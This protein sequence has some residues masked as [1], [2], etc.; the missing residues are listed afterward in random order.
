MQTFT[1]IFARICQLGPRNSPFRTA[2]AADQ[3]AALCRELG[4][5]NPAWEQFE[6]YSDAYANLCLGPIDRLVFTAHYDT[7]GPACGACD[8]SSGV[9]VALAAA[10]IAKAAGAE[11]GLLI[12]AC[13]EPPFFAR[14]MG[15]QDWVARHSSE[16][17]N[18]EI[19]VIDSL[20]GMHKPE[21]PS[22]HPSRRTVT[23]REL[24]LLAP[25]PQDGNAWATDVGLE[26]DIPNFVDLTGNSIRNLG[27]TRCMT[28]LKALL[29]LDSHT[30]D[31][32]FHMPQDIPEAVDVAWLERVAN[33]LAAL[34]VARLT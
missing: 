18:A 33:S 21:S 4:L 9:A 7:C 12:N 15:S 22:G 34:A 24:V 8:N 27:D 5:G 30:M 14:K 26:L 29:L 13:E 3:I 25:S 2:V 17:T 11:V 10:A 1:N 16:L 31:V 6:S 32:P 19:I 28:G 23:E 20:G